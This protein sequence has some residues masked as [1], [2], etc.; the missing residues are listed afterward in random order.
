MNRAPG[1]LFTV[2]ADGYVRNTFLLR[3]TNNEAA[4]GTVEFEVAMEGI[5]GAE[6]LSQNVSL[7]SEESR[8]VPLIVRVPGSA[9]LARTVPI[10]VRVSSPTAELYL[11]TTFK[12]DA[13][14]GGDDE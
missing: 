5:E 4:T 12:S 13:S 9:E 8:T 14:V 3:I 11:P 1:T 6:V 7:G 10:R 2:D